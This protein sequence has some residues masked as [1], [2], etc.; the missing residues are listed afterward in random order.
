MTELQGGWA[1]ITSR[2]Q[3]VFYSKSFSPPSPRLFWSPPH[4]SRGTESSPE[5]RPRSPA[6]RPAGP[7][8]ASPSGCDWH[9]LWWRKPGWWCSRHAP[10]R[11]RWWSGMVWLHGKGTARVHREQ[12]IVSRCARIGMTDIHRKCFLTRE[13]NFLLLLLFALF[14][15]VTV[16]AL[17]RHDRALLFAVEAF[18]NTL[19]ALKEHTH[20][21]T[22]WC[23]NTH[24]HGGLLIS[25]ET[26]SHGG[27]VCNK[28]VC[29]VIVFK[30]LGHPNQDE[31]HVYH[32]SFSIVYVHNDNFGGVALEG[33]LKGLSC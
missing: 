4:L 16:D 22:Q 2:D 19:V 30:G 31:K 11:C 1:T 17:H 9:R 12:E 29:C 27:N 8:T 14:V 13:L 20:T 21:H 24:Q 28:T 7:A 3:G 18:S 23:R 15:H 32:D 25:K 33:G 5:S 10:V 6:S 26:H